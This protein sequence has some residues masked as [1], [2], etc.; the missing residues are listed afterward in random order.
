MGKKE[1]VRI[2]IDTNVVISGLLF[3]GVPGNI[4]KLSA[5][6]DIQLLVS[7][8]IVNEYIKVLSYPKFRLNEDEIS[9]LLYHILLPESEIVKTSVPKHVI[10]E[11]DP[12]DDKFLVCAAAGNAQYL[13]SGDVHLTTLKQYHKTKIVRPSAFLQIIIDRHER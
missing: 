13:I 4:I 8:D 6:D 12:S 7:G 10:I 11:D 2:V 1:I 3:G 9:Y 5:R